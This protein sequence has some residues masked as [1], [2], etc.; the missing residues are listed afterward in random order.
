MRFYLIFKRINEIDYLIQEIYST[1]TNKGSN[2]DLEKVYENV[3]KEYPILKNYSLIIGTND[4]TNNY[5]HKTIP[6]S[7]NE[8]SFYDYNMKQNIFINHIWF[9]FSNIVYLSNKKMIN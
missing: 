4:T 8:Q 9:E 7:M 1:I 6:A 2:I 3:L 5:F